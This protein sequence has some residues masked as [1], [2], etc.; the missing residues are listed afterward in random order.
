MRTNVGQT[1]PSVNPASLEISAQL[2][3]VTP[4]SSRRGNRCQGRGNARGCLAPALL[5]AG[6]LKFDAR[7]G[8]DRV[9]RLNNASFEPAKLSPVVRAQNQ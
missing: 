8:L 2:P 3:G 6:D 7:R 5:A 9:D 1:L 4:H